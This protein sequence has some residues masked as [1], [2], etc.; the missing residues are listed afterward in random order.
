[1]PLRILA[2]SRWDSVGAAAAAAAPG[3]AVGAATTVASPNAGPASDN[4]ATIKQCLTVPTEEYLHGGFIVFS[5]LLPA[6]FGAFS[7]LTART[8][9]RASAERTAARHP[10]QPPRTLSA[11]P[12][13]CKIAA[14]PVTFQRFRTA[15]PMQVTWHT[16]YS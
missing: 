1:M 12:P 14:R 15:R 16:T 6:A 2:P 9:I 3:A 4:A 8:A 7:G 13:Q 10:D 11:W 5:P